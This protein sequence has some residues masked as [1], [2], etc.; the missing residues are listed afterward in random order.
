M[1]RS[2]H[3]E[4]GN[5][6][7]SHYLCYFF[8]NK[9]DVALAATDPRPQ[10]DKVTIVWS[11]F[12]PT[13][14]KVVVFVVLLGASLAP[15]WFY[16]SGEALILPVLGTFW[17]DGIAQAIGIPVTDG[18]GVDAFSLV[19]PNVTGMILIVLG[20]AISLAACYLFVSLFVEN[21]F[22][23]RRSRSHEGR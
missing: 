23:N 7:F 1:Q 3:D 21:V 11:I 9:R 18:P 17:L 16:G 4:P 13:P 2:L 6:G 22:M 10:D 12:K 20:S 14:M 19:P 8:A 15:M 5:S